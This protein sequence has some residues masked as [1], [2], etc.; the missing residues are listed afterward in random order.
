[1]NDLRGRAEKLDTENE[2]LKAQIKKLEHES[3]QKEQEIT[4]YHHKQQVAEAEIEK[5]EKGLKEANVIV[6]GGAHHVSE[7]ENLQRKLT[8]LEEEAEAADKT[9][10]ETN[11]KY[12]YC[13]IDWAPPLLH[14]E[15]RDRPW[16]NR[17]QL[18]QCRALLG[19]ALLTYEQNTTSE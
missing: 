7:N 4:S 6:K 13:S 12:D 10:R 1:M 3:L 17:S 8:V 9:L 15:T 5:L 14:T 19:F 18:T 11:E 16:D 2:E